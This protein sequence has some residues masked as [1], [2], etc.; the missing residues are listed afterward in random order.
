MA[1]DVRKTLTDAGYI[2]VGLGVLGFQQVQI[3]GRE[4][5]ERAYCRWFCALGDRTDSEDREEDAR[6][7]SGPIVAS[8][9]GLRSGASAMR[10]RL[11]G[12][13]LHKRFR[14]GLNQV[15]A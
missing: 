11:N 10:A 15:N 3:R 4:L 9:A 8:F 6:L 1:T 5:G 13:T 7:R 12:T 14:I 2:A